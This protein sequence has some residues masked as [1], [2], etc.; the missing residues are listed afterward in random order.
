[1]LEVSV[2]PGR[3]IAGQRARLAIRFT[4][5]GQRACSDIVFKLGLPAGILLLA[6]RNR[7]EAPAIAAGRTYVHEVTVEPG[8]PGNYQLTSPNFSYR[9]ELDRPVPVTD[10]RAPL[11]VDAAPPTP[12]A[13]VPTGRLKVEYVGDDL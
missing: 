13:V 8:R 2:E 6:G 4:N 7:M 12:A 3:L 5:T 9:H 1:M 10:F 11:L